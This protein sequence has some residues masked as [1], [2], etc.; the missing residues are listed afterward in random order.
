M[1][2]FM[3]LHGLDG[4]EKPF[5]V[6]MG[7]LK[8][9]QEQARL[10]SCTR[11]RVET[12]TEKKEPGTQS[13][14]NKL[15][16]VV[17][18]FGRLITDLDRF[19]FFLSEIRKGKGE[20]KKVHPREF[21]CSVAVS[22]YLRFNVEFA[23]LMILA[24]ILSLPHVVDNVSRNEFRGKCRA[25]LTYDYDA[26][27]NGGPS[28]SA[29]YFGTNV[30]ANEVSE[31]PEW[32]DEC[33]FLGLPIRSQI[34]P[35]VGDLKNHLKE[36]V[37][38]YDWGWD[39]FNLVLNGP[40]TWALGSCD[41]Y[42]NMTDHMIPVPYFTPDFVFTGVYD[43]YM[44][45]GEIA[46]F[47]F[48]CDL[49][50]VLCVIG[51]LIYLRWRVRRIAIE[52]D[53]SMWT[54]GDYSVL[55]RGLRHGLDPTAESRMSAAELRN[56][57][58]QDL[59]ELGFQRDQIKQ[60]EVGRK[61]KREINAMLRLEKANILRHELAARATL[62]QQA[63]ATRVAPAA[64]RESGAKDDRES[65]REEKE[66]QEDEVEL[67]NEMTKIMAEIQEL[68]D[69][70]DYATGH[71][72]I[73]FVYESDKL[74]LIKKL[75][76]VT[77]TKSKLG[78]KVAPVD[79][80]A[81]LPKTSLPGAK[82]ECLSAPEPSEINWSALETVDAIT[83][84]RSMQGW[85]LVWFSLVLSAVATVMIKYAKQ[86]Q[87][88]GDIVGGN[89]GLIVDYALMTASSV[90][91]AVTNLLFK[92]LCI[93]LTHREGRDSKTEYEASLFKK[94]SLAYVINSAAIP[95]LVGFVF[96]GF[97]EKQV[98]D[99]SWFEKSGVVGQAWLLLIISAFAKEGPK[100]FPI[101]AILRRRF[102][103][104]K[105]HAKL[106]KL[107]MP[108]RMYIGD[109]YAN[110]LKVCALGLITGPLYPISYLWAAFAMVVCNLATSF[111]ISRW[112]ARPPA[113][114]EEMMMALRTVL[115]CIL[116][117]QIFISTVA[118]DSIGFFLNADVESHGAN[119]AVYVISP[120]L[121]LAYAITP[122][123]KLHP[124]FTT[125]EEDD[126]CLTGDTN[127][128]SYDEVADKKGY[129]IEPYICPRVTDRI[130][131]STK[132]AKKKTAEAAAD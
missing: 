127:G 103:K 121:W 42:A 128:V 64:S 122:L 45:G 106:R 36:G 75:K 39:L 34:D 63:A 9:A 21:G 88:E 116:C 100:V 95:F 124:S 131:Y 50:V 132:A 12:T 54:A 117:A 118:A 70:P 105:S 92:W 73:A 20:G 123:S 56:L 46:A 84:K 93:W 37:S 67:D 68:Y 110:T 72:I 44:C 91:T 66:Q 13:A 55:L 60:I 71:A 78:A 76:G 79:M 11:V 40:L 8:Q 41:E 43:S 31:R 48:W 5:E 10:M 112:Y 125:A 4:F 119:I 85:A 74:K 52:E 28:R 130:Y 33:G 2:G 49:L 98:I 23:V 129:E 104:A 120:L 7:N 61:C 47:S 32:Y 30:S 96:S 57:L 97:A 25:T 126:D 16:E 38:I 77:G 111:G 65:S 53:K 26:L 86:Y 89:T 81:S 17:S 27:V 83:E 14:T 115:S 18:P 15:F 108:Q 80:S 35:L 101:G 113:V 87:L 51:F 24:F 62:L 1:W 114:D 107:W 99:Q 102:T 69:E 94:L 22:L 58:F 19:P 59:A 82:F 90:W 3:G 6:K 29:I 109:L